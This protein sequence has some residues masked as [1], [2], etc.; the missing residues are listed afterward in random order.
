MLDTPYPPPPPG[1]EHHRIISRVSQSDY[2]FFKKVLPFFRSTSVVTAIL[3]KKLIDE[4]RRLDSLGAFNDQHGNFDPG[5]Y[6]TSPTYVLVERVLSEFQRRTPRE[7]TGSDATR[8]ESDGVGGLRETVRDAEKLSS[9]PKSLPTKRGRN[10]SKETQNEKK[11][12]C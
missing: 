3:F 9:D 4:L 6:I 12:Q 2:H 1:F 7:P 5:W 10:R 8:D 11:E